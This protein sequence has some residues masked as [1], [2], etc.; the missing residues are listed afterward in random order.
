MSRF[1][2]NIPHT[3]MRSEFAEA[4]LSDDFVPFHYDVNSHCEKDQS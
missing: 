4:R 2:L 3:L 1:N